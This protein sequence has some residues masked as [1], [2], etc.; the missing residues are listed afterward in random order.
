V[1][2]DATV[3]EGV[4]TFEAE[5]DIALVVRVLLVPVLETDE[6]GLT[7]SRFFTVVLEVLEREDTVLFSE[8]EV[9]C[10]GFIVFAVVRDFSVFC[11]SALC[12]VEIERE[13]DTETVFE[14]SRF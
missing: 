12:V 2:L 3:F 9:V 1:L 14:L 7:T 4:E 13:D 10:S 6:A 11:L 5:R 8:T